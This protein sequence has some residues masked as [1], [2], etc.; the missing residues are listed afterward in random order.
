MGL[1]QLPIVRQ[2]V[3]RCAATRSCSKLELGATRLITISIISLHIV[4]MLLV[5]ADCSTLGTSLGMWELK[6]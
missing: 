6:K 1:Q 4:A 2:C 5:A 3:K